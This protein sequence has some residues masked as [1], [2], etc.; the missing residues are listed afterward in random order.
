MLLWCYLFFTFAEFQ[1]SHLSPALTLIPQEKT[2]ILS[3]S[4]LLHQTDSEF[5]PLRYIIQ[6]IKH[7][8]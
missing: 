8:V 6:K 5:A 2:L 7:Q 4:T 1:D 3:E